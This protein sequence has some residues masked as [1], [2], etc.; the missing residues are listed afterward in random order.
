MQL[1]L[2]L[3]PLVLAIAVQDPALSDDVFEERPN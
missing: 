3:C 2:F 1:H